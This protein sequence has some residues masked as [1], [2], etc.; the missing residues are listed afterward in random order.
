VPGAYI[1]ALHGKV[2]T[3]KNLNSAASAVMRRRTEGKQPS[4]EAL[5]KG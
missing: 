3:R 1:A 4:I 5:G 2:I